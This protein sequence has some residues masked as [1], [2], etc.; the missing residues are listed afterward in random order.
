MLT[1]FATRLT[2]CTKKTANLPTF[3]AA[4]PG[5]TLLEALLALGLM[6]L[7]AGVALP[8]WLGQ[9]AR[10]HLQLASASLQRA[11]WLAQL[12]AA[13]TQQPVTLQ[14]LP[15]TACAAQVPLARPGEHP[16]PCGW[17]L[18]PVGASQRWPRGV[19]VAGNRRAAITFAPSGQTR[20]WQTLQLRA[21][22]TAGSW[23]ATVSVLGRV[24]PQPNT[25]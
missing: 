25:P 6:A 21:R 1:I 22:H 7:V 14:P 8:R 17:A 10:Q 15:A 9:Q 3:G 11:A 5:F 24:N 20:Q 19:S 12:H 18:V 23:R 4:R 2:P 16:W 13:Q